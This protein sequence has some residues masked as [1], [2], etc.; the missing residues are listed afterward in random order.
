MFP[1]YEKNNVK[2]KSLQS[3]GIKVF[4]IALWNY[5]FDQTFPLSK[6]SLINKTRYPLSMLLFHAHA[7]TLWLFLF[8]AKG[9]P[10]KMSSPSVKPV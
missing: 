4:L 6:S 3:V 2:L 7:T 9:L 5:C 8:T 1:K 10:C